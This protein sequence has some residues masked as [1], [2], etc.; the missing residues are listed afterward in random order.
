MTGDALSITGWF[1]CD[2]LAYGQGYMGFRS[3]SGDGEF[4]LIQ[5]SNGVME[6]RLVTTNG[7]HEYV[8]PAG[9]AIPQ[10]WQHIAWVYDGSSISLY[11]N[12]QFVG[13][14]PASGTFSNPAYH[15]V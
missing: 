13:S 15:L 10:V 8:A 7:F 14:S 6:C 2:E 3:G 1:Y 4:Y 12:G 5:L 11:T 9:T